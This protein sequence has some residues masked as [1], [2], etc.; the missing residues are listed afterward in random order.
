MR[1]AS[2]VPW[3]R[4]VPYLSERQWGTVRED[5]SDNGDAWSYFTH[6]QARSR[7]LPLGRGRP[8][9]QSATTS[10]GCASR[11]RCGTSSDP[12]LKERLFGLTNAEGNHGEDVK[13]YYFYV[14]NLPTHAYQ[15]WLYKYPQAAYPY[16]DLVARQPAPVALSRWSTS[17]STP[18]SSPT[19]R[20]FDVEVEYAKADA[21]RHRRVASR[22]TTGGRRDGADPRPADALVPQHLVVAARRPTSG[23]RR[24][25][26]AAHPCDQRRAP[27]ARHAVPARRARGRAAVLRERDQRRTAVGLDNATPY[28]EGRHQRP[29]GRR[30]APTRQP[31]G[32][33]HQGGGPRPPRRARRR[34]VAGARAPDAAAG[35]TT[36]REPLADVDGVDRPPP[37]RGRR[38]LRRDH[39][40]TGRRP[41]P[42]R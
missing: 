40:A 35:P 6:D 16:D 9:R 20:Y 32:H 39:S 38:V 7:R 42:R 27:R 34:V 30:R 10:S 37:R 31:G 12:I 23:A 24:A 19:S 28:V 13:E 18:A 1:P 33:R 26:D 15:R 41:T 22:C 14:D 8:G 11:S 2:G 29:R 5:Y 21:R 17:C 25:L 36:L 3:R 4:G